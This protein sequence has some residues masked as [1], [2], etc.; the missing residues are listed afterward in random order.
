MKEKR[1][2]TCN[3]K[4]E[5]SNMYNR[6]NSLDSE[7][8]MNIMAY[9]KNNNIPNEFVKEIEIDFADMIERVTKTVLTH[10]RREEYMKIAT[11]FAILMEHFYQENRESEAIELLRK[12]RIKYK[13]YSLYY[14]Y[15]NK[16]M[17]ESS[18][19]FYNRY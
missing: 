7:E 15:I 14:K 13:K 3:L 19:K 12:N 4:H 16:K 1:L 11:Y 9:T 10:Q 18:A 17:N 5:I 2:L 6:S 8:I